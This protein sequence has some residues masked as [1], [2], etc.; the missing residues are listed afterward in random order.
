[1]KLEVILKT[2]EIAH[3]VKDIPYKSSIKKDANFFKLCFFIKENREIDR[4]LSLLD[5]RITEEDQLLNTSLMPEH[6]FIILPCGFKISFVESTKKKRVKDKEI[7]LKRGIA[8]GGFHPT[9][10]MCLELIKKVV[11]K[12]LPGR[13]LDLGTGSGILSIMA[14]KLGA[15][16]I[17][18]IDIDFDSCLE[19]KENIRLNACNEIEII[20]GTEASIKGKFT[21]IMVNIIFHTLR[22]ILVHL[23]YMLENEGFL[24]IS[25]FLANDTNEFIQLL[26]SGTVLEKMEKEGWGAILWQ[27][28]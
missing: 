17:Y 13:I 10:I 23:R 16:K 5:Q 25:G 19:C 7:L 20:C 22:E 3:I 8:F 28:K 2:P 11:K 4:I 24:V 6:N 27:K 9:T 15:K 26:N 18:A 21:L 1:M 14:E 12:D